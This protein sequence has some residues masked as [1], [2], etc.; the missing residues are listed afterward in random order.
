MLAANLAGLTFIGMEHGLQVLLAIVCAAGM[1]E[2]F[3]GRRIPT[4]CLA[5]AVLAPAVRY[6]DFALVAAVA[7][8]LYGQRRRLAAL[9]V[10]LLS[11][12]APAIFSLFLISRGLSPLPSSVL[13]KSKIYK[14]HGSAIAN[15]SATL[16]HNIYFNAQSPSWQVQFVLFLLLLW[17]TLRQHERTRRFVLAGAA[18]AAFLQ[19]FVGQFNWFY[20]YEV[21]ALVFTV[22]IAATA[23]FQSTRLDYRFLLAGLFAFGIR[24]TQAIYETPT[25]AANVYQQQYQ[26]HRFLADYYR[27]TVAV[28]DL[29]WISYR[30]PPGLYV[31]D[32]WG[33]ASPVASRQYVKDAAW[34]DAITRDHNAALAIIYPDWFDEAA[35]EDWKP[36]GTMCITSERVSVARD[37]VVFYN[38]AVGNHAAILAQL[39]Q[40]ARTL[41][42]TVHMTLGADTTQGN[43]D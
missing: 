15:A 41:P 40:F 32:L 7:I 6:E 9:A 36:L 5:A 8:T 29:G 3:A 21:Y 13:V 22:L 28:N 35:P 30:R 39:T 27:N 26:M 43:D 11:A 23:I 31:L 1:G 12:I 37:C 2:A 24:Y 4:W 38:T 33:L 19:T 18:V 20:R 25:A 16:G 34:L 17:L 10:A 14:F 42:P